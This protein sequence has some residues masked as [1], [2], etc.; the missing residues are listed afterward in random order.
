MTHFFTSSVEPKDMAP[1]ERRSLKGH[2]AETKDGQHRG[3]ICAVLE[4]ER[5]SYL[6]LF[7]PHSQR[8][9]TVEAGKLT[10]DWDAR[11]SWDELGDALPDEC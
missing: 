1:W 5:R 9:H 2:W 7:N 3:V 11:R 8:C 6:T 4:I 10:I